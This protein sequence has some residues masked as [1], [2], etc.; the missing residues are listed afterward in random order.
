MLLGVIMLMKTLILPISDYCDVVTVTLM[1]NKP[2]D[3]MCYWIILLD[4]YSMLKK[5]W[6]YHSIL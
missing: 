5:K 3:W 6:A 2:W 1:L 4:F